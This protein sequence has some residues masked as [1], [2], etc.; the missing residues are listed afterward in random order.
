MLMQTVTNTSQLTNV[1]WLPVAHHLLGN[2][3]A[4]LL[5]R[6]THLLV[7]T[8]THTHTHTHIYLYIE[9]ERERGAN[10][11]KLKLHA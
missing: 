5:V 11:M 8:H 2:V 3:S 7:N 9:R 1:L 4:V 6:V 10:Y